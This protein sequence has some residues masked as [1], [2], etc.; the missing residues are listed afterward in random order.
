M[1]ALLE[2]QD[3]WREFNAGEETVAAL[4]GVSLRIEAGEMLA[5]VGASGSGKSTL[6]NVLGCLDRPSRGS[7]CVDGRDTRQMDADE[8]AALRRERFGF[9]FQRYHLLPALDALANVEI[10]AVYAG[11]SGAQR[12]ARAAALLQRL[13]M[14]DRL[15]HRP[16]QLSGG[17]QQRV[18]I[19]RA[20]MN[21]GEVI[22]A[23]EPTGA[24]DT[25]SGREVMDILKALNAAGHTVIIVT[26]DM[27]VAAHARRIIEISDGAIVADRKT[28][29]VQDAEAVP[30]V[31]AVAAPQG[32]DGLLPAQAPRRQGAG[33]LTRFAEALR[34]ALVSLNAHRLR[35]ALTMLGI[36]IGIAAVVSVVALGQGTRDKVLSDINAMGTDTIQIFPG[37]GF[38]DERAGEI[39]T[40]VGADAEALAG[41]LYAD[42]VTPDVSQTVGLRYGN[43]ARL[44]VAAGVGDQ[45]FRVNGL[46]LQAGRIFDGESIRTM[47][48]EAVIDANT[49][50]E[51]FG[52]EDP[53]GKTLFLGQLPVRVIGIVA[54]GDS[55]FN[56]MGGEN[57]RVWIP[58]TA[59]MARLTG[60]QSLRSITVRVDDAF[61]VED[62]ER[63]IVA[64]LEQRHG[65]RD[66]FTFNM[67]SIRQTVERT[68]R[69]LTLLISTIAL[70]SLV[71]G[72][73]GVMNIMLVS[74]TERTREI[75]VRMAVGARRAD[76]MRQFLIEAVL[77]CLLGGLAGILLSLG[78]GELVRRAG[79]GLEMIYSVPAMLT[80]F[81]SATAIG[82]VF[83]FL[84][85]RNA[86]RLDPV[87]ALARD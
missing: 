16:A 55:V 38:G 65:V 15:S 37:Q 14:G 18:S 44:G 72:G 50:R 25:H 33:W 63:Q 20:L 5:I 64:F 61:A 84:P 9:I 24:L 81:A 2:L 85:A 8:L 31:A 79:I 87:E 4:R 6:M 53:L 3:V 39:R 29:A 74:V 54:E 10:P 11:A 78:L 32:Q 34:M 60:S 19:A 28:E 68:T 1:G 49:R 86:S 75:G 12:S 30:Q 40:L 41:Q 26:H 82:V 45:Y 13:G 80:A 36:V 69:A 76:I 17:Q 35:A 56:G 58:Y 77:V 73:I 23:D 57:L 59:A 83:G 66:F 71:V 47:A 52:D 51:L 42:S 67:D 48:Q 43:V 70:I 46:A 21:G 62:A 7:Y 27:G 22:L